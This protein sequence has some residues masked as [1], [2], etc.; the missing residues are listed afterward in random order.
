MD[1]IQS[2]KITT[3]FYAQQ[4]WN[5]NGTE[6]DTGMGSGNGLRRKGYTQ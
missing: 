5:L 2:R 4:M 1:L 6:N 3:Y